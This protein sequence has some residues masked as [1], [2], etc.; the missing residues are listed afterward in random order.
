MKVIRLDSV[1]GNLKSA[2]FENSDDNEFEDLLNRWNDVEYLR[3]FFKSHIDD[4]E[5]GFLDQ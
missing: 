5:S 1:E 4:L 2:V 3:E